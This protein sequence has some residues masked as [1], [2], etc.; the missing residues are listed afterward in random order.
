[1]YAAIKMKCV[2]LP[3]VT[4]SQ[5]HIYYIYNDLV[6]SCAYDVL[7]SAACFSSG[8]FVLIALSL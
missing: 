3:R 5:I 1:M 4:A 7:T 8:K 6:L 2:D